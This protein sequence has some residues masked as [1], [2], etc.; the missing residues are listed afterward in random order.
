MDTTEDMDIRLYHRSLMESAGLQ[1][2]IDLCHEIGTEPMEAELDQLQAILEDDKLRWRERYDREIPHDLRSAE[3]IWNTIRRVTD[4][5]NVNEY[6][7]SM[8]RHLLLVQEERPDM[9]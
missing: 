2:I 4:N 1:R 7:L 9:V 5:T 8:M 3:D 6:F